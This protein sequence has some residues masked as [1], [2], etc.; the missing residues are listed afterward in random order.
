MTMHSKL[1]YTRLFIH[2]Q[3][4]SHHICVTV[5][6]NGGLQGSKQVYVAGDDRDAR[7]AVSM[8]IRSAGFTPVDSGLLISARNIED[9]PVSVFTQ[10]R[11]P[12]YIHLAIF[13]FLYALFFAKAQ[14]LENDIL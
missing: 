1:H 5:A 2:I 7:D 13:I 4:I 14:V 11:T 10:W 8:M 12:F 6:E 9:I 3:Y